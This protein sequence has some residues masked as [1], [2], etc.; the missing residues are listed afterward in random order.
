MLPREPYL[1]PAGEN[2]AQWC[3]IS[4]TDGQLS[5]EEILR[6]SGESDA[7]F[8]FTRRITS[9]NGRTWSEPVILEDATRQLPDGGIVTYPCGHHHD[10]TLD[11]SYEKKMRRIWPGMKI[12]TFNW[13]GKGHPFNDHTFV[14][15]NGTT[16]KLLRYE[17]GPDYN[18]E[19][20]FDPAFCETNRAYLGVGMAFASDGT[21]F[22]P[23]VCHTEK[24]EDAFTKGGLVLMRRNP[25]T[26]EWSPSNRQYLTPEQSSRG[27]LEPDVAV[28][29]DGRILVVTRGNR[30]ETTPGY[31]WFSLST[32]GGRTLSPL[33]P[34]Q[35]DDGS[36]FYSPSSIH[37]FIRSSRNGKLYW[38]ANITPEPPDA[39]GPRYPL[40]IAEIDEQNAAVIK[41]SLTLV[42]NRGPNE[43]DRLQL[44]NFSVIE[45]RETQ[46]IEIYMTR[47]GEHPDRFWEAGVYK[48]TFTPSV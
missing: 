12:Y 4:Y 43:P 30:T 15:E 48:Y 1:P 11:I 19:N 13:G 9:D 21:A 29:K 41:N 17:D 10:P 18:P 14:V 22:Y 31:K 7:Y 42:D 20:P 45:N 38:L 28:L 5:R 3:S 32:D 26:G 37:N 33:R 36:L 46:N 27:V 35:Y 47:L 39:N 8:D 24:G 2:R 6:S 23:L 25:K 40:C 16:E 34:F 44:S